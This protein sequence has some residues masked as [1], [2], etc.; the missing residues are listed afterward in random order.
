MAVR[1]ATGE[2]GVTYGLKPDAETYWGLMWKRFRQHRMAVG[3]G[4]VVLLLLAAVIIVPIL[5][6]RTYWEIDPA[7]RFQPPSL[8]HPFGTDEL[9]RDTFVRVMYGGRVSLLVGFSGAVS[10]TILGSVVGAIAGYYGGRVDSVL[11]RFT[12]VMLTLPTLPLMLFVSMLFH[13][14]ALTVI[15]VVAAF[16]WMGTARM[17][18]GRFLS[19]KTE[20]F[21]EAALASGC[22]APRIIFRH[23]LPNTADVILVSTTL[24]VSTA[25]LYE[26]TL[27]FLGFGVQPPT[28]TWGNMLQRSMN[29]MLGM[30]GA[31]G[32]PWWLIFFPGFFILVT[33]L[34]INFLGDGMRDA[35]DPKTLIRG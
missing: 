8:S 27:S 22:S 18:R 14:G 28:P 17:V 26:A 15:I 30:P 25:I 33:V 5:S 9:G 21:V 29:Y 32:V 35:M 16:F 31:T 2:G 13:G 4:L 19:L 12:D 23:L 24:R 20:A 7:N 1:E 6:S 11:M 10:A 3:S 34:C